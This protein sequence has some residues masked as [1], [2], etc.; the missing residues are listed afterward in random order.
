[1]KRWDLPFSPGL[2]DRI[3]PL[4]ATLGL[5]CTHRTT[6]ATLPGSQHW[7]FKLGQQKGVVE[8]TVWKSQAWL[9]IQSGRTTPDTERLAEQLARLLSHQPPP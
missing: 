6:L 1:M 8:I 7:H 4:A 3:E 9:S 5:T 2:P